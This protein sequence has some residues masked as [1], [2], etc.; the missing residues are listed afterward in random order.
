MG[1]V[2][3]PLACLFAKLYSVKGYD[4]NPDRVKHVNRGHD[5]THETEPEVMAD[6]LRAGMR[7]TDDINLLRKCNVYIICVPTPVDS[8][9]KPDLLPLKTASRAVGSILKSGDTVIYESSVY[10]GCTEEVCL[11]ILEAASGLRCNQD[12]TVGYS[13]E[14]INPGDKE[15]TV[16]KIKKIVSG[17]TPATVDFME[18]LYGSI[19][20]NDT[21]RASSIKVAEATKVVENTQRDIN[22]AFMNELTKIFKKIGINTAEVLKCAATKW[23]FIPLKPGL[24][25]GHCIGI[26]PYYLIHCAE[27]HG[28]YPRLIAEARNVN[29]SMGPF[30]AESLIK[31]MASRKMRVVGS[32]ILIMGFAFKANCADIRNTKVADV[33]QT[34]KQFTDDVS[35]YDPL[36]DADEVRRDYGINIM[37]GNLAN[38]KNEFD[39]VLLCVAH[40]T[41]RTFDTH[42]LIRN[43]GIVY[44]SMYILPDADCYLY[45]EPKLAYN[46]ME[47]RQTANADATHADAKE[48]GRAV[49]TVD[50]AG[51]IGGQGKIK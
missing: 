1:Y 48:A 33:Y 25:G 29:E 31:E 23:N 11:P 50:I 41:F 47:A 20:L 2:G 32:K 26:D 45:G 37:T 16:D 22:I 43:N 34:L 3:L 10:P 49:V 5:F 40:D 24:V 8:E 7:A 6:A 17:T 27:E 51:T 35:I 14:R 4:L 13:P 39:A 18:K 9:N 15:H 28:V 44:D 12:F 19:L 38:H 46:N 42:S 30:L 36:V 21:C